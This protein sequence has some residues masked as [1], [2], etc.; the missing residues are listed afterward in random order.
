M[1]LFNVG[2]FVSSLD[3][4]N[5]WNFRIYD[6]RLVIARTINKGVSTVTVLDVLTNI[7]FTLETPNIAFLK[8]LILGKEF[9]AD[10]KVYTSKNVEGVAA[11]FTNFFEAL[12]IDQEIEDFI[13]AYW[14]YP[15]KIRFEL[16]D[17]E[18]T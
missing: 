1:T 18:E 4:A 15:D 5:K 3:A 13:R 14:I 7:P 6:K 9:L 8:T 17:V 12:D 11:D 16:V 2:I 10:L